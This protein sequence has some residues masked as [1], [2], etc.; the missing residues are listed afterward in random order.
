MT[1]EVKV[2]MT[3]QLTIQTFT[4]KILFILRIFNSIDTEANALAN[5]IANLDADLI[6]SIFQTRDIY[7][8]KAQLRRDI[9]DSLTSV[10]ILIRKLNESDWMFQ[11]Q[12]NIE[13]Q[14]THLFFN[15][16]SCQNMLKDNHEILIMNCIYKINRYKMFLMIIS[17]QIAMK[18]NFYVD[19]C[20]MN[21][22]TTR[23]IA[24]F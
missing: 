24:E 13:N 8:F 3:R 22:K 17:D 5:A 4:S 19:F 15:K 10:Q 12:K 11:L 2:E 14:I 7:N 9:L 23:I 16:N 21:K 6:N 18:I 1:E 20:F